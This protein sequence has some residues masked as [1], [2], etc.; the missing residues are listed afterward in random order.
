MLTGSS[1]GGI[2]TAQWNNYVRSLLANPTA[3][4]AIPDSGVFMNVAS[5]ESGL[6]YL[7]I[8]LKTLYKLSNTD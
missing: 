1:A 7:D 5:P 2:A 6:F 4:V 3:M 8:I